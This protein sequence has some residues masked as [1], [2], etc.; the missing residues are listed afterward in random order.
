MDTINKPMISLDDARQL[1]ALLEQEKHAEAS[2]L[3][4]ATLMQNSPSYL[5]RLVS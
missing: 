3:I 4:D 2:A 1:V 5:L